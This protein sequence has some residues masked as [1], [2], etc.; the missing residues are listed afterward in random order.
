MLRE[1]KTI[2]D[3]VGKVIHWELYKKLKFEH[4]TKWYMHKLESILEN[5]MHKILWDFEI[6][7]DPLIPAWKPDLVIINKKKE[8]LLYSRLCSTSIPLSENQRKQKETQVLGP[9]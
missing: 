7:T 3:R 8:I 5:E 1:Y 2:H 9:C 4:T 6:Q